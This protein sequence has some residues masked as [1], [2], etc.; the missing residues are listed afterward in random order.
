MS[1]PTSLALCASSAAGPITCRPST[2]SRKPGANRSIWRS[3]ASVMS[4]SEPFGTWQYAHSVC[5][6]SGARDGSAAGGLGHQH[7]R[8]LGDPTP[9]HVSFGGDHLREARSQMNGARSSQS[10][11]DPG[12]GSVQGPVDL[13]DTGPVAPGRQPATVGLGEPLPCDLQ[14]L[15]GRHVEENRP[16]RRQVGHRPDPVTGT[17]L[18]T[19]RLEP[20]HEG[21]RDRLRPTHRHRPAHPV[22]QAPQQQ[23]DCRCQR[24]RE[25][26]RR[27]R[28]ETAEERPGRVLTEHAA[29]EP[30]ARPQPDGTE[31][32]RRQRRPR[33][34]GQRLQHPVG[35]RRPAPPQRADGP[36]PGGPV[37]AELCGGGPRRSGAAAPSAQARADAPGVPQDAP[38]A[39]PHARD[40]AHGTPATRVRA[41]APS[42]RRRDG[43]PGNVS[44]SV[45][46]PPP[47]WSAASRTRTRHPASASVT[48]ATSPFGPEPTTTASTS[49]VACPGA[50]R[51]HPGSLAGL[52]GRCRGQPPRAERR[53]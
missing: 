14:Q 36:R 49:G 26:E 45:R 40:R 27:V 53:S 23:P 41:G 17:H 48:A 11:V 4:T 47:Y 9:R 52:S 1:P 6:P 5:L 34:D 37:A 18:T 44:S 25:V 30:G 43:S 35:H 7:V 16:G 20:E 29:G 10:L 3:M 31:R 15:K 32:T 2:R 38:A 46:V 33:R 8:P 39:G 51:R 19:E 28:S 24:C 50:A 13:E 21:V 42:S 22:R 12:H